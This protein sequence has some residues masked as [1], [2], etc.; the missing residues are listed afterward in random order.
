MGSLLGRIYP[1]LFVAAIFV[2]AE[3]R[4]DLSLGTIDYVVTYMVFGFFY[5]PV[6]LKKSVWEMFE[7]SK[8]RFIRNWALTR[9]R[10]HSEKGPLNYSR[11]M[12]IFM[13]AAFVSLIILPVMW[14]WFLDDMISV[15]REEL[16]DSSVLERLVHRAGIVLSIGVALMLLMSN[17]LRRYFVDW[18]INRRSEL[19]ELAPGCS[20]SVNIGL[21]VVMSLFLLMSSNFGKFISGNYG[22]PVLLII[23]GLIALILLPGDRWLRNQ[24]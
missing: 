24:R 16:S 8:P 4:Y 19:S 21:L 7:F 10:K 1:M 22:S 14:L 2:V 5:L 11:F 15:S 12:T 9:R 18:N 20:H 3:V 13:P 6:L 23:Q 17:L